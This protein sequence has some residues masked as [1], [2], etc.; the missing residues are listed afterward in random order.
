MNPDMAVEQLASH[1]RI[2]LVAAICAVAFLLLLIESIRRR[3]LKVRYSLLWFA[4]C[5]VVILLTI[6]RDWLASISSMLG[7]Y[8]PP[9]ALFL[10]LGGFVIIVL[11]HYSTVLSRLLDDRTALAQRLAILD[12]NFQALRLEVGKLRGGGRPA[13]AEQERRPATAE[14]EEIST[15]TARP[16]SR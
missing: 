16:S 11:F 4:T 13:A 12:A 1:R 15:G 9:N 3:R 14:Q 6:K 5:A 8:H 10:V 2:E 7:I